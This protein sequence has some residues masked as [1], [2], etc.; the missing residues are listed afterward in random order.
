MLVGIRDLLINPRV[1]FF[2]KRP[3]QLELAM[4][5][6]DVIDEIYDDK[7]AIFPSICGESII[8]DHIDI[9]RYSVANTYF[10]FNA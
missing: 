9:S 4:R 2:Q 8:I 1:T 5:Y 6:I 10:I 7:F 3:L